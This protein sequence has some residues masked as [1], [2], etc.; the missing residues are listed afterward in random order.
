MEN[1]CKGFTG[2]PRHRSD[3]GPLLCT[4]QLSVEI[5]VGGYLQAGVR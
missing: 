4:F 2:S 5:G 1:P 3:S